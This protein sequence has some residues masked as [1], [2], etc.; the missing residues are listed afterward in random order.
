MAK[1]GR[2]PRATAPEYA[3]YHDP[4][5]NIPVEVKQPPPST[6]TPAPV[7][8][9][10]QDAQRIK[11]ERTRRRYVRRSGGLRKNLHPD[12]A[13]KAESLSSELGTTVAAGWLGIHIPGLDNTKPDAHAH[14]DPNQKLAE[15]LAA[16]LKKKDPTDEGPTD[17]GK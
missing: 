15:T 13:K 2:P 7:A 14:V 9:A 10:E 5:G 12:D 17:E 6:L 4:A 16:A 1:Q 8:D 11:L 3:P